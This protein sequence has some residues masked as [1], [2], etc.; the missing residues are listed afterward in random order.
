[1]GGAA[2][3]EETR[4][5]LGL[6]VADARKRLRWKV[7]ELAE[8]SGYEVP[9]IQSFETGRR[10]GR[11]T[12]RAL[13]RALNTGLATQG[14]DLLDLDYLDHGPE[15][16]HWLTPAL[17]PLVGDQPGPASL[18]EA[19]LGIVP[20]QGKTRAKQLKDLVDWCGSSSTI[21]SYSIKGDGG[22]GKT[23]LAVALCQHLN[24]SRDWITGFILPRRF[25]VQQD[26]WRTLRLEGRSVLMVADY[27]SRAGMLDVLN[28][29]L[30][31]LKELK[32]GRVRILLLDR[33]GLQ[34]G[35][36]EGDARSALHQIHEVH[37]PN[38]GPQL[39][40]VSVDPEERL[41]MFRG[42]LRAFG[43]HLKAGKLEADD[44]ML[45]NPAGSAY[46]QVLLLHMQALERVFDAAPKPDRRSSILDR[47]LDR[48]REHWRESMKRMEIPQYLFGAAEA[49]VIK[50][51]ELGGVP[52]LLEASRVISKLIA[53]KGQP[54]AIVD[55]IARMLSEIYPDEDKGIS[56]LR[57][58]PLFD[59]LANERLFAI[60]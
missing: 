44:H 59:H 11:D 60:R 41:Q 30:P 5:A 55:T 13:A 57:P 40:P 7:L 43:V 4:K 34:Q 42:A 29:V 6:L 10:G 39:E 35:L 51:S 9:T 52:N 25:P 14:L 50:I 24:Q 3:S 16:Q 27:T 28:R 37:L 22:M 54:Q 21:R 38:F 18:L 20:W 19:R 17:K 49:A 31:T 56:P 45:K 8:K 2:I 53:F 48:E 1:M 46:N 47:L 15:S 36:L 33:S 12:Y 32:S 23:R 26:W 58:D